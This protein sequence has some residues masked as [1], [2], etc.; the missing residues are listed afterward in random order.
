MQLGSTCFLFS[1]TENNND[2]KNNLVPTIFNSIYKP[3]YFPQFMLEKE[4]ILAC[5]V[6]YNQETIEDIKQ[7]KDHYYINIWDINQPDRPQVL[8]IKYRGG[9]RDGFNDLIIHNNLLYIAD[10]EGILVHD[11][12]ITTSEYFEI[13]HVN[14]VS[15]SLSIIN[16]LFVSSLRNSI[17]QIRSLEDIATELNNTKSGIID[18]PYKKFEMEKEGD[19]ILSWTVFGQPGNEKIFANTADDKSTIIDLNSQKIDFVEDLTGGIFPETFQRRAKYHFV[20]KDINKYLIYTEFGREDKI[21]NRVYTLTTSLPPFIK[22]ENPLE[23]P[24]KQI[25]SINAHSNSNL[26]LLVNSKGKSYYEILDPISREIKD[27]KEL[28]RKYGLGDRL[29]RVNDQLLIVR[30]HE[31]EIVDAATE[32]YIKL[33]GAENNVPI[34]EISSAWEYPQYLYIGSRNE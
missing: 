25:L 31:D 19:T 20:Q 27:S 10:G 3:C 8:P 21:P 9:V 11:L 33:S 2:K 15:D 17:F 34:P 4:R 6:F 5:G 18:T 32:D 14:E 28:K 24:N 29:H 26:E 23:Y 16:N 30:H 22:E 13:N 7:G 1:F 12:K